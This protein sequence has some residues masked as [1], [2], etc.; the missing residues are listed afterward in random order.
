MRKEEG[1]LT[2][3]LRRQCEDEGKGG[4]WW[5]HKPGNACNHQ[6]LGE[7]RNRFS[8]GVSGESAT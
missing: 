8:R 4:S 6:K 2:D 1:N 5:G 3:I 7:V